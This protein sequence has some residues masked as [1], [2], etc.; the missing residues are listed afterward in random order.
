MSRVRGWL[1]R[2]GVLVLMVVIGQVAFTLLDFDPRLRDWSLMA[3]A[4]VALLWL[5]F[6]VTASGVADWDDPLAPYARPDAADESVHH[7]VV[8]G[9]LSAR[10]PGPALRHLLLDLARG[11][12]P[13]LRDPELRALADQPTRRLSPTDIDHYLT[14][15]EEPR[16]HE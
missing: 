8:S 1:P 10:D 11:R 16:D 12:D 4:I 6:D 9:H 13:E 15:I 14:R 5:A 7:R 2:V 3:C